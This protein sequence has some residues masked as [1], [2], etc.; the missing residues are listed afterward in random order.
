[1]YSNIERR[2]KEALC[3]LIKK[4]KRTSGLII[5]LIPL[6]HF[7]EYASDV[8]IKLIIK[9]V[10]VGTKREME[11]VHEC[12]VLDKIEGYYIIMMLRKNSVGLF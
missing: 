12:K 7:T 5:I 9:V 8:I 4:K 10:K 2:N 11:C 1:M 6:S 3:I